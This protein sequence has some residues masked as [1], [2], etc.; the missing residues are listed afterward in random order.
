MDIH[1]F[2]FAFKQKKKE[3]GISKEDYGNTNKGWVQI[4]NGAN[5]L[6]KIAFG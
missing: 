1:H 5:Y 2:L 3:N 6:A 4:L